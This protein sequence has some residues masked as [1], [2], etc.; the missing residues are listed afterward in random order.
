MKAIALP[1][2][3]IWHRSHYLNKMTLREL[4]VAYFQYYAIPPISRWP[5]AALRR[6]LSPPTLLQGAV[7]AG[8]AVLVYPL[9]WYCLHRSCCTAAGCG[10]RR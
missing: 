4:V 3:E 1:K 7:A 10:N 6:G 2:P 5:T 9:V 8:I